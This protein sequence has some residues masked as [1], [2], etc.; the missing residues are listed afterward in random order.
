MKNN[1]FKF[2]KFFVK[3]YKCLKFALII[4]SILF[5]FEYLYLSLLIFFSSNLN[6]S[7]NSNFIVDFWKKIFYF[8]NIDYNYKLI[9]SIFLI[10]YL[11]KVFLDFLYKSYIIYISRFIHFQLN[12]KIFH[13]IIYLEKINNL[14]KKSIGHYIHLFGD[15]THKC[16]TI[17]AGF[18]EI[19]TN[20]LFL[21]ASMTILFFFS[22]NILFLLILL[23]SLLL[24]IFFLN[25]K[26]IFIK[27]K[28]LIKISS[29]VNTI[30]IEALN[31]IRSI[32]SF[33]IGRF[34]EA[35][36]NKEMI[37][38]M[39]YY[40]SLE[41]NKEFYKT[42]PTLVIIFSFLFLLF[43]FNLNN[44]EELFVR[45]FAGLILVIRTVSIAGALGHNLSNIISEFTNLNSIDELLDLSS[46]ITYK[47]FKVNELKDKN[48]A[49][50]KKNINEINIIDLS[51][52]FNNKYLFKDINFNFYK[53]N[54]YALIGKSGSGKSCFADILSGLNIDFDGQILINKK[55]INNANNI[56]DKNI[57]LVEQ[58]S[59]IIEGSLYENLTLGMFY[60]DLEIYDLLKKLNLEDLSKRLHSKLEYQGANLSGGQRQRIAICR[61]ILLKPEVLILDESLNALDEISFDIIINFLFSE[62]K[63]KILIFITHDKRI[64]KKVNKILNLEDYKNI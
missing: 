47:D 37:D 41:R 50:V 32:R 35:Q 20:F 14:Y 12:N 2:I 53:N 52:G 45:Y 33:R 9:L 44:S 48:N 34:I 8:F 56:L 54:S 42:L 28:E 58:T 3:E 63:E 21:I 17:I 51:F 4:S 43:S 13:H 18:C 57:I 31:S 16:G 27:N 1:F 6:A 39:R 26:K 62:F 23:L 38:Y 22:K 25:I 19:F 55:T 15:S 61:A 36:N 64:I 24:I 10:L 40:S 7:N 11:L 29:K 59:K 46:N 49:S 30:T 5:L 60:A